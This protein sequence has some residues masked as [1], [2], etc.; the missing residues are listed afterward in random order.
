GR[1][2]GALGLKTGFVCASGFNLVGLAQRGGR[3]L[4]AVTL[5]AGSGAERSIR[6]AQALDNGFS[7][8]GSSGQLLN[9]LPSTGGS[10]PD[11]RGEI[12]RG[13]RGIMLS[14]DSE[15][16]GP[17]AMA[18][19]NYRM[20][21]GF[22]PALEMVMVRQR[23]VN[24]ISSGGRLGPRAEF[25]P[26]IIALGRTSGSGSAP[27]AAN[28]PGGRAVATALAARAKPMSDKALAE[29]PVIGRGVA[30]VQA[31]AFAPAREEPPALR[32][33]TPAASAA[34][35]APLSLH[36]AP[37]VD[38]DEKPAA[39]AA[40]RPARTK[41][42][43]AGGVPEADRAKPGAPKAK[44]AD[45]AADKAKTGGKALVKS[46]AKPAA[47]PKAAASSED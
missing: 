17:I 16:D 26:E 10:A 1:Y 46:T 12:C 3:T 42:A 25:V 18:D 23:Q 20:S 14:D 40:I 34:I 6:T 13:R 29:K 7:S 11:M 28:A 35:G 21:D 24:Q 19:N 4:I 8:W 44:T 27:I 37:A 38:E 9:N 30:P 41:Q 45:K 5:G 47:K 22:N 2:P 31:T 32:T 43:K 36:A 33:R 15:N 39:R